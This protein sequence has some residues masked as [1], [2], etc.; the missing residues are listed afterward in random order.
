MYDEPFK[1][2]WDHIKINRFGPISIDHAT[3]ER[4]LKAIDMRSRRASRHVSL[5]QIEDHQ[6]LVN[7]LELI[8]MAS[9]A[10]TVR[11]QLADDASDFNGYTLQ[12]MLPSTEQQAD[13]L[14][15][16]K[17]AGVALGNIWEIPEVILAAESEDDAV[18]RLCEGF[19]LTRDQA[20]CLVELRSSSTVEHL[21][22]MAEEMQERYNSIM[23]TITAD[24]ATS[25]RA[26]QPTLDAIAELDAYLQIQ[27]DAGA[28]GILANL[29]MLSGC[30]LNACDQELEAL[31]HFKKALD[32]QRM[33]YELSLSTK[34]LHRLADVYFFLGEQYGR[35]GQPGDELEN[36]EISFRIFE[37]LNSSVDFQDSV[38]DD[39]YEIGN[40]IRELGGCI[41]EDELDF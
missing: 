11:S 17:A 5:P 41:K 30:N 40:M 36:Y 37:Y 9:I 39:M 20:Q 3:L 26:R 25:E 24:K 35:T 13:T 23:G 15:A 14:E 4:I 29:C 33:S 21:T 1:H 18:A 2:F 32:A 34:S 38:A 12:Q 7:L 6:A 31:V 28:A 16:I 22:P 19:D 27:A 10:E 8:G